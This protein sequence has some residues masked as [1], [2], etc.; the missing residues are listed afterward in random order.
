MSAFAP[1]GG[2][3]GPEPIRPQDDLETTHPTHAA[4]VVLFAG[5]VVLVEKHAF[6]KGRSVDIS[7]VEAPGVQK[8]LAIVCRDSTMSLC[9]GFSLDGKALHPYV[10]TSPEFPSLLK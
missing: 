9:Q 3:Q 8:L 10:M 7:L 4:V 5:R 6:H 2:P 1:Q